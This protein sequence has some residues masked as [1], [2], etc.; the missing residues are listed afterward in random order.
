MALF[1]H[2]LQTDCLL[3]LRIRKEHKMIKNTIMPP[4]VRLFLSING[5]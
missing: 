5:K 3:G 4:H 1:L 2:T